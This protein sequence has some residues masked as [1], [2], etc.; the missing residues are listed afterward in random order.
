MG[1]AKPKH[2]SAHKKKETQ[3]LPPLDLLRH[4]AAKRGGLIHC[5]VGHGMSMDWNGLD[6]MSDL[7]FQ[8][9]LSLRQQTSKRIR[10][11]SVI[12]LHELGRPD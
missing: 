4:W 12:L 11:P 10:S 5:R 3:D 2:Q 8:I 1:E 6:W 9:F 7:R